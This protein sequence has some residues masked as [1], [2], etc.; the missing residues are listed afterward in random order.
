MAALSSIRDAQIFVLSPPSVSGLG[1]SNG[2]TFELQGRGA[3][4][5]NQLLQ[6]RNQLIAEANQD[7]VL[8]AVRANSLPDLPQLDVSIDDAKA[9]S[10]GPDHQ[11]YQ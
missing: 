8:S 10:L 1:Q 6:M 7:P 11:R 3:T 5:R 2:F 9:Q 4:D